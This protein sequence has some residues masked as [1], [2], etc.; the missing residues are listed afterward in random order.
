MKCV[1]TAVSPSRERISS[2]KSE[3]IVETTKYMKNKWQ[4]S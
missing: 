2:A 3:K 4:V 1:V